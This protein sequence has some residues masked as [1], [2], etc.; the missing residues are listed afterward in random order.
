MGRPRT[1]SPKQMP[2]GLYQRGDSGYFA[3]R[4]P[5]N[6]SQATLKTKDGNEALAIYKKVLDVWLKYGKAMDSDIAVAL[7]MGK[8]IIYKTPPWARRLHTKIKYS[9]K[10]RGISFALTFNELDSIICESHGRCSLTG[11]KLEWPETKSHHIHP[12]LPSIDRIN[13]SMGYTRENV[14]IVCAAVNIALNEWGVETLE[15]VA[16]RLLKFKRTFSQTS[17]KIRHV[18]HH[19]GTTRTTF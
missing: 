18:E 10:K 4:N 1:I 14:R 6:G 17:H 7:A 8:D 9:A 3:V 19:R 12:W 15:M 13:S 5:F 16:A 2:N 11:I